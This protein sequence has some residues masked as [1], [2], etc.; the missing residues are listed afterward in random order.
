MRTTPQDRIADPE[1]LTRSQFGNG[2]RN[3]R[4]AALSRQTKSTIPPMPITMLGSQA[5]NQ[6]ATS[7]PLASDG[8]RYI[9]M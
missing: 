6:G 2:M 7:L 9:G 3:G 1:S 5:A 8:P 4:S